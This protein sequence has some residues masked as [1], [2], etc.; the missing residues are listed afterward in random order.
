MD[1]HRN[2]TLKLREYARLSGWMPCPVGGDLYVW[3]LPSGEVLEEQAAFERLE[4]LQAA[5]WP[6]VN[7]K[8]RRDGR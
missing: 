2:R 7:P 1:L 8:R 5:G 4:A 6:Q 3:R